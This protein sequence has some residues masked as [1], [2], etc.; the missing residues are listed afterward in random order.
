MKKMLKY[1][2][3]I[4]LSIIVG[5]GIFS[6]ILAEKLYFPNIIEVANDGEAGLSLTAYQYEPWLWNREKIT[7]INIYDRKND[8]PNARYKLKGEINNIRLVY[9]GEDYALIAYSSPDFS[10]LEIGYVVHRSPRSES[11]NTIEKIFIGGNIIAVSPDESAYFYISNS[12]II[13][14]RNWQG[15]TIISADLE[16]NLEPILGAQQISTGR[17]QA[18]QPILFFDN[19]TKLAF[20]GNPIGE[21]WYSRFIFIWDLENNKI[22]KIYRQDI[23][24]YNGLIVEDDKL[25]VEKRDVIIDKK[26]IFK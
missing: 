7:I 19:N 16:A 17:R 9:S 6:F 18:Y 25:Y 5:A 24:D 10:S 21:P 3:I 8:A 2:S 1:I 13:F 12:G 20:W 14:K 26:L 23:G 22:K 11:K 15:E 4:F